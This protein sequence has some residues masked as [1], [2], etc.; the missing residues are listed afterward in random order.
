MW[1]N[2]I[3]PAIF[4]IFGLEVRYYGLV[5]ALG[6]II[7][8]IWLQKHREELNLK[9]DE[10]YDLVFYLALGLLIGARLFEIFRLL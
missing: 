9:K 4:S 1:I 5:Y 6:F 10:V 3:N 7:A 8:L 2:N